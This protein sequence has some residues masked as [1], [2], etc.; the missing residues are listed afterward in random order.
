MWWFMLG[1]MVGGTLSV[2][3]MCALAVSASCS[4]EEMLKYEMQEDYY[5]DI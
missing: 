2:V 3:F 5:D 4:R 1:V